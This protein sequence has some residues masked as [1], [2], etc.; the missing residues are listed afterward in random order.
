ME[1]ALFQGGLFFFCSDFPFH[2]KENA[3]KRENG[4]AG[5]MAGRCAL[6]LK[7]KG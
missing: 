6:F 3:F 4:P 2:P 5:G 7:T 1:T